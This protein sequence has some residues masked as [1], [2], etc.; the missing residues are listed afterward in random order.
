MGRGREVSISPLHSNV[1]KECISF[2]HVCYLQLHHAVH[3]VHSI[4][5]RGGGEPTPKFAG[6]GHVPKIPSILHYARCI[7]IRWGVEGV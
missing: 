2:D 5:P 7:C 4:L 1:M 3:G 6:E